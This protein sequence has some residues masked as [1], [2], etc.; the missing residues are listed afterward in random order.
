M[1]PDPVSLIYAPAAHSDC[2]SDKVTLAECT[3]TFLLY[4]IPVG[5]KIRDLHNEMDLAV[6]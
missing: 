5:K 4:M 2:Y 1:V 6:S 3:L